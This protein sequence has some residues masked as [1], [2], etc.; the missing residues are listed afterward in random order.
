MYRKTRLQQSSTFQKSLFEATCSCWKCKVS[1]FAT[2]RIKQKIQQSKKAIQR[3][4]SLVPYVQS[5]D[6]FEAHSELLDA[7]LFRQMC[8]LFLGLVKYALCG[9]ED[10]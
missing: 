3:Q 7:L 6:F 5:R 10:F 9:C 8:F 1:H 2:K 4:I